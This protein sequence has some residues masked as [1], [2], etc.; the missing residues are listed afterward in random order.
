MR[1]K[2]QR[3]TKGQQLKGKIVSAL[4]SH[5]S[6]FFFL[7]AFFQNFPRGLLLKLRLF[8]ENKKK[9][10][11]PFCTLV[12][13]RFNQQSCAKSWKLV[14]VGDNLRVARLQ[15]EFCTNDFFVLR[16]FSRK[17]L[18]SFPRKCWAFLQEW[19]N[20]PGPVYRAFENP[21]RPDRVSFC[22]PNFFCGSGKSPAKFPPNSTPKKS[23]V[24]VLGAL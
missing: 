3:K 19:K 11:K 8:I 12:V 6:T 17:M 23:T 15:N 5:F 22:T 7:L 20:W 4:F 1:C 13:A 2:N 16:N 18:R 9:K 14:E 10:T 24:C 21:F